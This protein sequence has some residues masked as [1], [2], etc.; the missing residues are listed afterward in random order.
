M[1]S[2]IVDEEDVKQV[3]P[4]PN[5]DYKIVIGNSL[6]GVEKNLFNDAQFKRLEILKPQFFNETDRQTKARLKAQIEA[7]IHELTNGRETFDFEIFFS[8]V[9]HAKGGFDVVIANPPYVRQEKIKEQK[10]SLKAEGYECYNGTADLLV[11]FYER[12]V[13]LLRSGGVLTFITSNKF[14]RAG[15]G[16]NCAAFL[17]ANWPCNV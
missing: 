7:L 10:Q 6:L 4:L 9:F 13:K 5:L 2:L 11:Y 14:Y 16:R 12:G 1:A 17:R 8:E 3:K 15:Y